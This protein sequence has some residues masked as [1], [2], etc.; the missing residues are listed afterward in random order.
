MEAVGAAV[1]D[2]LVVARFTARRA[3]PE[4][5]ESLAIIQRLS[6]AMTLIQSAITDLQTRMARLEV[7]S[8]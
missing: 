4:S 8:R 7:R 6:D 1:V 3:T 5:L 2:P